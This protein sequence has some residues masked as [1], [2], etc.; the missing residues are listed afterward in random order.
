MK[1]TLHDSGF[2][3]NQESLAHI[4]EPEFRDIERLAVDLELFS[5]G[6][7]AILEKIRAGEKVEDI[8][9]GA[10][11]S[12]VNF[13]TSFGY[14]LRETDNVA[15]VAE[16]H[17]VLAPGGRFLCDTFG[18]D[19]VIARLVEEENLSTLEREYRIRRWW[20][21]ESR[22]V[23]TS[24]CRDPEAGCVP[25]VRGVFVFGWWMTVSLKSS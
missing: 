3:P 7:M 18:R 16:I 8:V 21:P 10:F 24:A 23:A 13:F 25:D 12:V 11:R 1:W 19:H 6:G 17:R 5:R 14:F 20:N 2:L 15:V 9:K 4:D 22:R